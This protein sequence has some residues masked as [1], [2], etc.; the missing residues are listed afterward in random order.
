[1]LWCITKLNVCIINNSTCFEMILICPTYR[2]PQNY[3][4]GMFII[5]DNLIHMPSHT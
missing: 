1:M 2:F 3:S 5:K 4:K